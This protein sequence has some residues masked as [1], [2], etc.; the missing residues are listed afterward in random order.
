MKV[1]FLAHDYPPVGGG[2][3]Q[4]PLHLVRSLSAAGH[5]VHVVTVDKDPGPLRDDSLLERHP[6]SVPITRYHLPTI[7]PAVEL[8]KK[9][10]LS[11]VPTLV[12][13]AD[14]YVDASIF[15]RSTTKAALRVAETFRPD[16]IVASAPPFGVFEAARRVAKRLDAAL[17]LDMRDPWVEPVVGRFPSPIAF[18]WARTLQRRCL[19]AAASVVVTAPTLQ[20]LLEKLDIG[21][22]RRVVTI[23]NGF[24]AEVPIDDAAMN[25]ARALCRRSDGVRTV[26]FIGRLFGG[27]AQGG[28]R[29][30]ALA[31]RLF[32]LFAYG[33][34]VIRGGDYHAG[35][36]F[37]ALSILASRRPDL[38]GR[39]ETLF[40]GNVP[41]QGQAFPGALEAF[42]VRY[43]GYQP[44]AVAAATAR[45]ADGLALFNPSTSDDSPS[46][47]IPGKLFEYLAAGPPIFAMCGPGDCADIVRATGAGLWVHDREPA[48]MS[49]HLERWLDGEALPLARDEAA[50]G[51]YARAVLGRRFVAEVERAGATRPVTD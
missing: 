18:G 9:A 1:M 27:E 37:H 13:P 45:L 33:Q 50:I 28:S 16:V 11:R 31:D 30:G 41:R 20:T 44:L 25:Q 39:V 5:D 43:A 15:H 10:R 4:R 24:D 2:G 23:T 32:D 38:H 17:V 26:A 47:I 42:P 22:P 36:W 40:V 21:R 51:G 34:E 14:L 3:V 8:F 48:Q 6:A 7:G 12:L 49:A 29:R 46:F 19:A 35:P